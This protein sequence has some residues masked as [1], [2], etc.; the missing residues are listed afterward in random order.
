MRSVEP[1]NIERQLRHHRSEF[2]LCRFSSIESP[3]QLSPKRDEHFVRHPR[4]TRRFAQRAERMRR[5]SCQLA[6]KSTST[7]LFSTTFRLDFDLDLRFRLP[8][9][10]PLE[11]IQPACI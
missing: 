10:L 4:T 6:A 8:G 1:P 7:P 11:L 3:P 9:V 2:H 5:G